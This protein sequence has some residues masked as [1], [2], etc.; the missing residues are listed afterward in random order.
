MKKL[1]L[2]I[3]KKSCRFSFNKR[4]SAKIKHYFNDYVF[5]EILFILK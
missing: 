5:L 1:I 4:V 2:L 3:Y